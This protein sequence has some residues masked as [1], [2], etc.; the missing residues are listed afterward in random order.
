MRCP[1]IVLRK[2]SKLAETSGSLHL[3]QPSR[4]HSSKSDAGPGAATMAL[5]DEVPPTTRPM[6]NAIRLPSS[7][8]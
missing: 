4:P 2:N 3:R 8:D 5:T 7:P 6:G 1:E